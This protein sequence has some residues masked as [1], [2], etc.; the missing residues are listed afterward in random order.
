MSTTSRRSVVVGLA[1]A[2]LSGVVAAQP[3]KPSP[4]AQP[5]ST[6]QAPAAPAGL[7]TKPTG[8]VMV[9]ETVKGVIEVELFAA[10]APKTVEHITNLVKRGF[11]TGLRFHRVEPKFVAQVGDP[12]SRDMTKQSEWG[13][14]GS[15]RP[16]GVA[17]ISKTRVHRR[18]VVA[19]AHAGKA[20]LADAQFYILKAERY[21]SLDGKYAIFGQVLTGMDVVD[22]IEIG[23]VV[24][25]ITLKP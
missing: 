8:P 23:D 16:V 14:K 21:P 5:K 10:E 13:R 3:A 25:R 19:M 6:P 4:K 1:L 17:E 2:C 15:G 12:T 9:I 22:K 7:T 24:K 18:G 11:Y 20:E